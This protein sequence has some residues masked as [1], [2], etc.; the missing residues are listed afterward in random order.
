MV[1][2]SSSPDQA[3]D[4][5]H[6]DGIK[7]DRNVIDRI[8]TKAGSGQLT[9]RERMLEEFESGKMEAGNEFE[10][11]TDSIQVNGGRTRTR[12]ELQPISP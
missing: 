2:L 12:S 7:L 4:E 10:G 3:C 1:A 6:R 9:V 5:L 11:Q 8:V